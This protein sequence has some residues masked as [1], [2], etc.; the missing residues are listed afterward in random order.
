M[1]FER[2]AL[3]PLPMTYKPVYVFK[4]KPPGVDRQNTFVEH[5]GL[6]LVMSECLHPSAR[7]VVLAEQ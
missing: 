2:R 4:T 6:Y 7:G 5:N 1:W 3:W